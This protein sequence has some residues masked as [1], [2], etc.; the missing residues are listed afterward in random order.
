MHVLTKWVHAACY[1]VGKMRLPQSLLRFVTSQTPVL[2]LSQSTSVR[3]C[4]VSLLGSMACLKLNQ[5]FS[6]WDKF[7][8]IAKQY[9]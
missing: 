1:A 2:S 8:N 4:L 7:F 6:T 5:V 9:C 3:F